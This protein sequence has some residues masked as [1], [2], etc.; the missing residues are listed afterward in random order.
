[1]VLCI[2]PGITVPSEGAYIIEQMI[3]VQ[4]QLAP[5]FQPAADEHVDGES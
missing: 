3:T 2:E 4:T 1:M 5:R